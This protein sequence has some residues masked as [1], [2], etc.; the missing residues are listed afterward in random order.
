[1]HDLESFFWRQQTG[2]FQGA[3]GSGEGVLGPKGRASNRGNV[4]G[5]GR[6]N[7]SKSFGNLKDF[8]DERKNLRKL[9]R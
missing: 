4:D 6:P 3:K 9:G 2:R 1:M 7:L 5:D 8:S